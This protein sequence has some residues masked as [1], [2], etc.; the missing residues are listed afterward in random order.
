LGLGPP[1]NRI[2]YEII[3]VAGDASISSVQRPATPAVYLSRLQRTTESAHFLIRTASERILG[4]R[5]DEIIERWR[6][7]HGGS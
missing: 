6:Q 5:K 7:H 3:G 2:E 4:E 1:S